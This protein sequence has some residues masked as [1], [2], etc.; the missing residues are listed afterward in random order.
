MILLSTIYDELG[1]KCRSLRRNNNE[2]CYIKFYVVEVIYSCLVTNAKLD[3]LRKIYKRLFFWLI[4]T[5]EVCQGAAPEC[6][7]NIALSL[8][9]GPCFA[10]STLA[11][12]FTPGPALATPP[13]SRHAPLTPGAGSIRYRVKY[14]NVSLILTMTGALSQPEPE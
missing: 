13:H 6:C 14:S 3:I 8:T 9:G 12:V 10:A 1:K 5:R 11:P 7:I 2:K 4:F